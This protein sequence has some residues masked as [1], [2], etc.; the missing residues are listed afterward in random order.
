MM[1]GEITAANGATGGAV[2]RLTF[3][4]PRTVKEATATT[5]SSAATQQPISDATVLPPD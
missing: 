1:G 5:A 4:V 2:F 3:P